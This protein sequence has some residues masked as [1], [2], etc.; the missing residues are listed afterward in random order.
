MSECI[1]DI[2]KARNISFINYGNT[3]RNDMYREGLHLLRS[4]KFLLSNNVIENISFFLRNAHTPSACPHTNTTCLDYSYFSDLKAFRKYKLQYPKN[5][6]VGYL[7]INSLRNK[8]FG[9]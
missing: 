4:G 5:S 8:I 2:C 7:N 3:I 1:L 6:V 9:L